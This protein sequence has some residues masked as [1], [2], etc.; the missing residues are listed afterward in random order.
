MFEDW[1]RLLILF[2]KTET[3][4]LAKTPRNVR[5]ILGWYAR[6]TPVR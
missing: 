2:E 1:R 5:L 6:P 4:E 3:I